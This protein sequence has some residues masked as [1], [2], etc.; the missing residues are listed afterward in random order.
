MVDAPHDL[1]GAFVQCSFLADG[2]LLIVL[3][4]I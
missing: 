3:A 2:N 1:Q 4:Q